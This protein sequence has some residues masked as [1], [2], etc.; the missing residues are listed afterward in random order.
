MRKDAKKLTADA[1]KRH[2]EFLSYDAEKPDTTFRKK[3]RDRA[4]KALASIHKPDTVQKV[5]RR[6]II[7]QS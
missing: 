6:V 7:K 3:E 2:K 1:E 4:R 5:N